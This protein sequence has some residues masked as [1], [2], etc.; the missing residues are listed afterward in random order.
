MNASYISMLSSQNLQNLLLNLLN[1]FK[2]KSWKPKNDCFYHQTSSNVFKVKKIC[3]CWYYPQFNKLKKHALWLKFCLDNSKILQ[4]LYIKSR[5]VTTFK[6]REICSNLYFSYMSTNKSTLRGFNYRYT[7][8]SQTILKKPFKTMKIAFYYTLKA[9]F[10]VK[11]VKRLSWIF[12][13]VE[14]LLD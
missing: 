2:K 3:C 13:R 9:L 11:I 14:K 10:T 5:K 4:N 6:N 7:L 1:V 8:M 12:G